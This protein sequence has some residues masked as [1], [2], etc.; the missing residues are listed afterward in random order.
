MGVGAGCRVG[1]VCFTCQEE[2]FFKLAQAGNEAWCD[3]ELM[4]LKRRGSPC[5]LQPISCY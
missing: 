5:G 1:V 3:L 2:D 4:G